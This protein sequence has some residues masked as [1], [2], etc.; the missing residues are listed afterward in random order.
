MA[1]EKKLVAM[2]VLPESR[3]GCKLV[4][5]SAFQFVNDAGENVS[6][7]KGSFIPMDLSFG[8][9]GFTGMSG[10]VTYDILKQMEKGK[11]YNLGIDIS[12]KGKASLVDYVEVV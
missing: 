7:V 2:C 1:N 12:I 6:G 3:K 8:Q 4:D 5:Y 9:I 11:V 10:T